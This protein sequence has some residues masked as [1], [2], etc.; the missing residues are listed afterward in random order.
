MMTMTT[1][2]MKMMNNEKTQIHIDFEYAMYH[3]LN[4]DFEWDF[5]LELYTNETTQLCWLTWLISMH[6]YEK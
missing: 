4:G 3:E 6:Q 1:I 5:E 2:I